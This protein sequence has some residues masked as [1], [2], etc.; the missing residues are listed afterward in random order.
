MIYDPYGRLDEQEELSGI[1]VTKINPGERVVVE[2]VNSTYTITIY[3]DKMTVEGGKYFPEPTEAALVGSTFGGTAMKLGW[4][5]Y[6][7]NMEFHIAAER[8]KVTTSLVKAA[9]VQGDVWEYA[10]EWPDG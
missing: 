10:M 5:G 7:M 9:K 4:I 6:N 2:T 8:K 3:E 1:D